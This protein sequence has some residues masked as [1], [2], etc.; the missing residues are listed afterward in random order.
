[1]TV[2][3]LILLTRQ[4]CCLCKGLEERL[5]EIPLE[6]IDPSLKLLVIDIDG[7]DVSTSERVNYDLEVPVLFIELENPLR[8]VELPRVSPRLSE[9]GL[10]KWLQKAIQGKIQRA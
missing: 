5:K 3:S 6:V 4:G 7:E 10:L 9:E 2:S 8:K 1:M